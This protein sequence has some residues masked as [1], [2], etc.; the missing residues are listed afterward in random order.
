MQYI[1]NGYVQDDWK[2]SKKLTLNF[3]LR[4]ELSTPFTEEYN[5]QTNFVLDSGPRHL[6][7]ILPSQDWF[8]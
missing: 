2:V 8:V 3:G 6:Q 5:R 1:F 4:Y 7:L